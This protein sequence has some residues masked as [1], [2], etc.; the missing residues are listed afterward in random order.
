MTIYTLTSLDILSFM[1]YNT[2]SSF[3]F[4]LPAHKGLVTENSM[5]Q[6][7]PEKVTYCKYHPDEVLDYYAGC[8]ECERESARKARD[9]K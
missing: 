4:P 3:L 9:R 7:I 6:D 8:A 2:C 1:W 5:Y